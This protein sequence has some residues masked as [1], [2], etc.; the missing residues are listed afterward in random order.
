MLFV[1]V[2]ILRKGYSEQKNVVSLP[3]VPVRINLGVQLT[4][5][6]QNK[7]GFHFQRQESLFECSFNTGL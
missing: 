5:I 3:L 2:S 7:S 4:M 1:R 6:D